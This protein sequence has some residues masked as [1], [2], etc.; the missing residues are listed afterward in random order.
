MVASMAFTITGYLSY[1]VLQKSIAVQVHPIVAITMAYATGTIAGI[2]LLL[3]F[4]EKSDI[5]S[6][7]QKANWP[8]YLL[9][10]SV[11]IMEIG[12]ILSYRHGWNM[13]IGVTVCNTIT[14]LLL[15]P[16]GFYFFY[17]HF[18]WTQG[19]GVLLCIGG[20]VLLTYKSV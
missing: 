19:Y 11:F 1:H 8:V 2:F 14:T 20:L 4:V 5:I 9:G 7:A 13:S 12:F 15:I 6:S 16:I 10:L 3:F 18:T 17:E